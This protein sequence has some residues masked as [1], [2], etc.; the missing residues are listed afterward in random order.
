MKELLA[1][2]IVTLAVQFANAAIYTNSPDADAFVRAAAPTSNYGGA[3]ALSVSGADATNN[4]GTT[5]GIFDTFIRFNTGGMVSNFNTLFGTNN[6]AVNGATL[7]VTETGSPNNNIFNLG[8]GG[9]QIR[10]IANDNWIEGTGMP[11]APTTN[12]ITYDSEPG[13]LSPGTEVSLGV[14]TNTDSSQALTLPLALPAS[15]VNDLQAGGEVSFFM[16]ATDPNTGF[17]FNSRSFPTASSRPFLYVS[18]VSEPALAGASISGSDVLLEG[19]NGVEGQ[20]Y[21]VLASTD[22][23]LPLTQWFPIST[24]TLS[25]KGN[26]TITLT[27]AAGSQQMFFIL[28]TH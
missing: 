7:Q 16:T 2:S 17:T 12:G 5:N 8:I 19:L 3:G 27:N 21:Y 20:T 4:L 13:L 26:F 18:A 24:N 25:T 9:F 11:N 6:W 22:I 10:W 1:I 15:F 23:A 14:F 28:Q